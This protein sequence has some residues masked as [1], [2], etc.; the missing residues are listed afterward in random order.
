[1]FADGY[2]GRNATRL[3]VNNRAPAKLVVGNLDFGVSD[4]DIMVSYSNLSLD[5]QN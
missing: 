2:G 3:P 4:S 5:N 1:M